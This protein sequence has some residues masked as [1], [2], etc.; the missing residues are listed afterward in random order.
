MVLD[1]KIRYEQFTQQTW[2]ILIKKIQ[3]RAVHITRGETEVRVFKLY[4]I[5][6]RGFLPLIET[7]FK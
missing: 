6:L 3:V 1:F 5:L 2:L 4:G 7:G